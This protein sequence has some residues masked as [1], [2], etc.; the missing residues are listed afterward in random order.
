MYYNEN[1]PF[2]LRI[3]MKKRI[4]KI[5]FK[6]IIDGYGII[7]KYSNNAKKIFKSIKKNHNISTII[8]NDSLSQF[9]NTLKD[10]TEKKDSKNEINSSI[11][12]KNNK[13]Y[14]IILKAKH[15]NLIQI[16]FEKSKINESNLDILSNLLKKEH[17]KKIYELAKEISLYASRNIQLTNLFVFNYQ[18][19]YSIRYWDISPD[20]KAH[21][22]D[23]RD[24]KFINNLQKYVYYNYLSSEI[25]DE[26]IDI[27]FSDGNYKFIS[28]KNVSEY[29]NDELPL[30]TNKYL[31]EIINFC[32][33]N[34]LTE[35]A[36]IPLFI[37]N[38]RIGFIAIFKTDKF[39]SSEKII[40]YDIKQY[41]ENLIQ[42]S[43]FFQDYLLEIEDINNL[44]IKIPGE[45][46][47]RLYFS[48]INMNKINNIHEL[49][50]FSRTELKDLTNSDYCSYYEIN[51]S[52]MTLQPEIIDED[53]SIKNIVK[54]EKLS[55]NNPNIKKIL[56]LKKIVF[57]NMNNE[58]K[59]LFIYPNSEIKNSY[60]F[61][62]LYLTSNNP[63]GIFIL[64]KKDGK[65]FNYLESIIV[66]TFFN[67][68][69][70]K[71]KELLLIKENLES[72]IKYK[73]LYETILNLNLVNS[74][75]NTFDTI[76][77]IASN[78]VSSETVILYRVEQDRN[79]PE[80]KY[81]TC[82][83]SNEKIETR[84]KTLKNRIEL[85]K[86]LIGKCCKDGITRFQNIEDYDPELDSCSDKKPKSILAIPLHIREEII[87]G[88]VLIRYSHQNFDS[89]D[90][91]TILPFAQ[92]AI[93]IV[94]QNI[95]IQSNID[96]QE[97]YKNIIEF[98]K[99]ANNTTSIKILLKEM[100]KCCFKLSPHSSKA[101]FFIYHK[102][103]DN[104]K[105]FY[106][107]NKI[108][109]KIKENPVT[110]ETKT[111]I[112]KDCLTKKSIITISIEDIKDNNI[113]LSEK[114][115]NFFDFNKFSFMFIP[116]FISNK[117]IGIIYIAKSNTEKNSKNDYDKIS[118]F[119][120]E[121]TKICSDGSLSKKIKKYLKYF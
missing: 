99:I 112:I 89:N 45:I 53:E 97:T 91:E 31:Q 94:Y 102:N 56:N 44:K 105:L 57:Y 110:F 19:F 43:K 77:K 115:N 87:G 21:F 69:Q 109:T 59:G 12:C 13:V 29:L 107:V 73:A 46:F 39:T 98:I 27:L 120:E 88:M 62:P 28:T 90:L 93:N 114:E 16:T 1:I 96:K 10:F 95:L 81:L 61:C 51:L 5:T 118:S 54:K 32:N 17:D 75:F 18:N 40:F 52:S 86:Y 66:N 8:S 24:L 20:Y 103:R 74:P 108:K 11:T 84:I 121:S 83:Y 33:E 72:K 4:N 49:K 6:I 106:T 41:S 22:M 58:E 111:P 68:A 67:H 14:N 78:L 100:L 92:Q 116:L 9:L 3:R 85:G 64:T 113:L 65:K 7:K 37:K 25:I 42:N 71:H 117:L 38:I 35:I 47:K 79:N 63:T 50:T 55:L 104:L 101:G 82:I 80:K 26:K 119:L 2:I 76:A 60:M 30:K 70:K 34:K 36:L 15:N 23:N 48:L